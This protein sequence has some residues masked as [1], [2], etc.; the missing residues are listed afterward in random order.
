MLHPLLLERKED[1]E[2]LQIV[3]HS[4]RELEP[5]AL[6]GLTPQCR[7]AAEARW[8]KATKR[9]SILVRGR[10]EPR[11]PPSLQPKTPAEPDEDDEDKTPQ[12]LIPR[13]R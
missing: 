5:I 3:E 4:R 8:P 7:L 13:S 6:G 12:F 1:M 2:R 11:C 9:L 10:P